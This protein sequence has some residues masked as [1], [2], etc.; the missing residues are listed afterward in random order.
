MTPTAPPRGATAAGTPHAGDTVHASAVAVAG[1]G[2]L[3]VGASGR[4]K[5]ALALDLMALGAELV[6]D[7]RTVLT[8]QDGEVML[9][10]P[11]PLRGLIEARHVGLLCAPAPECAPLRLVV[12]LDTPET[13]RLPPPR[14][15]RMLGIETALLHGVARGHFPAAIRQYMLHGRAETR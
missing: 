14:V 4:G 1:R 5:S 7:D 13:E 11:E 9:S 8:V 10:A 6:A 12:D 3:I 15:R 2:V